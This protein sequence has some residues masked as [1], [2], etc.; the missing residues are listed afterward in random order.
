MNA[1]LQ[2]FS[3]TSLL[4]DYFLK[5]FKYKENDKNKIISNEY[6]KV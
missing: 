3:N 5:S 4:T 1:T 6:Y 2:C